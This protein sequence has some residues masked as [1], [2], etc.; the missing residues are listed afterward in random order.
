DLE[1]TPPPALGSAQK[2]NVTGNSLVWD[3]LQ[4]GTGYQVRVRA[5][6]L[7]P[8]PSD[9]SQFSAVMVPAGVPDA[10]GQPQTTPATPVGSQAQIAV[11]WAAPANDNGDP[12]SGYTLAVKQGGSVVQSIPVSGTS[13]NVTVDTSQ[14]DYTFAVTARNKAGVSTPSAD[15][16]PRRAATAPG[17]PTNVT[18]SPADS[19]AVLAFTPGALNG[20]Q[21]SEVTYSY[22]VNQTGATGT[23]P[24]G[25]GT[26][27]GLANGTSYT[28]NVWATSAVQGVSPSSEATSTAAVP[29]GKP[30]VTF[31]QVNRQDGAVQFVWTVNSNGRAVTSASAP[32][33]NS[34]ADGTHSYTQSGLAPNQSATVNVSYTN[35]AGTTST[36]ASGQAN[37]PPPPSGTV[38]EGALDPQAG[39]AGSGCRWVNLTTQNLSSGTYQI[40]CWTDNGGGAGTWWRGSMAITSGTTQ[41]TPCWFG[42]PNTHV[43]VEVVGQLTTPQILWQ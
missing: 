5:H 21:A 38:S 17:A 37:P 8:D 29:F 34:T 6:N 35:A 41:Q 13:Q 32:D 4:N 22:R 25:G 14:T 11:S 7:A 23:V 30:I 1:I 42:Y 16:S 43:W 31:T 33:G 10:P 39:C 18:L 2:L 12:V 3:G 24:A 15:S 26:I 40:A 20:S 9:W 36:S 28:A 19:S 27:G